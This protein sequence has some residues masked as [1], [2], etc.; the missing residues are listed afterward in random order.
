MS[1][2][3][4]PE[5]RPRPEH[6]FARY[7]RI[8]GKGRTG[9]RS[10]SQDEAYEAFAMVLRGETQPVQLGAFLMLL[11]VK[12]ESPEEIAGFVQACRGNLIAPPATLVAD[13]DWSSYAGKKHQHP[14]FI[15][16]MLLLV[17]YG[18]RIFVHGTTG[19]TPGRLYTE[20]AMRELGLPVASDWRAVDQ[21]LARDRLCYMSL[22]AF[23]PVLQDILQLKPLLGLRSPVNTLA[24][25]INPLRAAVSMQ[26]VFHPAYASI[27]LQADQLLQQDRTMVFKGESGEVEIKPQAETRLNYLSGGELHEISLR[28]SITGR[29]EAVDTPA[30]PPLRALWRG[31]SEDDYGLQATLLT[32]AT[33]L[34]ALRPAEDADSAMRTA[35]QLWRDR[36]RARFD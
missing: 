10:L 35:R 27:H 23:C 1:K 30:T 21:A 19:H 12:E 36:D 32:A 6:P 31:E 26:S 16:S 15:L 28:R 25:L 18:C 9:S 13:I 7:I 3:N 5:P 33:A 29:V 14:W 8:L 17:Q 20:H 11:R 4:T 22:E 24:R 2:S 34:M